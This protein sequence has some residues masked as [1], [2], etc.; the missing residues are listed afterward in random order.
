MFELPK[1]TGAINARAVVWWDTSPGNVVNATQAGAYPIGIAVQAA[2]SSD[3]TCRVRLNGTPRS[4]S[5]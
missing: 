3:A 2:G 5:E 4:L 1:A